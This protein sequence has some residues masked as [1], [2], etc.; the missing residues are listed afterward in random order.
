MYFPV[1]LS[2]AELEIEAGMIEEVQKHLEKTIQNLKEQTAKVQ[3]S[4]QELTYLPIIVR[5]WR[6]LDRNDKADELMARFD[7]LK[8]KQ[9]GSS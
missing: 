6:K 9:S 8:L 2:Y 7:E 3:S 5:L 1:L 4:D